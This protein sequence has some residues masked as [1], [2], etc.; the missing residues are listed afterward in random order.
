L[1]GKGSGGT[2]V[3]S[4][5]K[6][7]TLAEKLLVG[8]ARKKDK[9]RAAALNSAPIEPFDAPIDLTSEERLVWE[10]LAP[11]AFKSKTLTKATEYQF[12]LLCRN[13]VL[14]RELAVNPEMRGGANHRGILQRID[15]QLTKFVLSPMGKP[16]IEDAPK[17]D[18]PFAAFDDEVLN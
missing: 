4:G 12:V 3:G 2:R 9:D 13:V 6:P 18:D 14:E 15:S 17:P 1:G 7:K 8:S 10:R 16:L 5:Q 11:S